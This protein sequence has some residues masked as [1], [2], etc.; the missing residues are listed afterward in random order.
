M[1]KEL[2][3]IFFM[4][5]I[6]SVKVAL[7]NIIP[8]PYFI[9][10]GVNV[11]GTAGRNTP[12]GLIYEVS[13][14]GTSPLNRLA[15]RLS[16]YKIKIIINPNLKNERSSKAVFRQ[17]YPLLSSDNINDASYGQ[18]TMEIGVDLVSDELLFSDSVS[19]ELIHA[20]KFLGSYLKVGDSNLRNPPLFSYLI[21]WNEKQSSFNTNSYVRELFS[22][23]SNPYK[24]YFQ[25]YF[26]SNF[27]LQSNYSNYFFADEVAA[28]LMTIREL[29]KKLNFNENAK[30]SVAEIKTIQ[31]EIEKTMVMFAI[32]RNAYKERIENLSNISLNDLRKN[33]MVTF[34]KNDVWNIIDQELT[35]IMIRIYSEDKQKWDNEDK[36]ACE[37]FRKALKEY[38]ELQVDETKDWS[39]EIYKFVKTFISKKL[40][41]SMT[42]R[43]EFWKVHFPLKGEGYVRSMIYYLLIEDSGENEYGASSNHKYKVEN[44]SSMELRKLSDQLKDGNKKLDINAALLVVGKYIEYEIKTHKDVLGHVKV[45]GRAI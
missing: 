43:D 39:V 44:V 30:I 8:I 35:N 17:A 6:F 16:P 42:F 12:S 13:V 22:E 33:L 34:R 19:H 41:S 24:P 40:N 38:L 18:G 2:L 20:I 27:W 21:R 36:I 26:D 32:Q 29:L 28:H 31:D 4:G 15:A 25:K 1:K 11:L 5:F 7:A 3:F 14:E 23:D 9:D 45:R 37:V 10:Q